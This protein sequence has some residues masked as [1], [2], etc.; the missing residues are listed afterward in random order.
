MTEEIKE[1]E[2][3]KRGQVIPLGSGAFK[4][5]IPLGGANGKRSYHNKT[6]HNTTEPKAWKYVEK[7]F[8][9]IADGSY[10]KPSNE[11]V[12][13]L[14]KKWLA[15]ISKQ[16]IRAITLGSYETLERNF[17]KP[18]FGH[19][20]LAKLTF[21]K[22]QDAF[23]ELAAEGYAPL[24]LRNARRLL[25]CVLAFGVKRG[26]LKENPAIGIETPKGGRRKQRAMTEEEADAFIEAARQ[27]PDDLIFIFVLCTGL[28]PVEFIGLEWSN[29]ELVR[30]YDF[31]LKREVERG[32][33]HIRRTI[34]RPRSGGGWQW[35]E[36]KTENSIRDIYFPATVYHDLMKHKERQDE[37]KR[38]MGRSYHDHGLVFACSNG[39]P[40]ERGRLLSARFKPL[41][42]RAKLPEEFTL[43][44]LRRTFATLTTAA[45]ASRVGRSASM[46]H[47]DADFTDAVYVT[48]LPSMQKGVSDA[49]ENLLFSESRTLPAHS[50][51]ERLM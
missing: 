44:T 33:A 3:R 24:T 26:M 31:R 19:Y 17:I 32:L 16:G 41:A 35:S 15:H 9:Q 27:N 49:L 45:G 47:A 11:T 42:K 29:L 37:H 51:N 30:E 40:L 21:S 18:K 38:K 4:V 39:E 6:L 43:Y 2:R 12:E 23:D 48:T 50:Q 8:S 13:E 20:P 7:I 10:F 36:P 14:S 22:I 46:G 34:V 5:R 25:G 1:K 28:R